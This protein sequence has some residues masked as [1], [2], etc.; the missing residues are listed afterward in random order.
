M[1]HHIMT[2]TLA[3]LILHRHLQPPYHGTHEPTW[4][5]VAAKYDKHLFHHY[6]YGR[7]IASMYPSSSRVGKSHQ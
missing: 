7:K 1:K 3:S 2:L 5:E 6:P 4:E